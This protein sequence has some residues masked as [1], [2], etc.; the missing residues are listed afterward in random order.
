MSIIGEL[1]K[2][3]E[4]IYD[5]IGVD[6]KPGNCTQVIDKIFKNLELD[7]KLINIINEKDVNVCDHIDCKGTINDIYEST[8][9]VLKFPIIT[10]YITGFI[11]I[12]S[13][14]LLL[15]YYE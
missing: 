14:I 10:F 11:I 7:D 12:I 6:C 13:I 2:G 15:I 5:F 3:K 8:L 1:N 9:N 4:K